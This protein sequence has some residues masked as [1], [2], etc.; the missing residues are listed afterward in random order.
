MRRVILYSGGLDSYLMYRYACFLGSSDTV[1]NVWYD[2]GQPYN[3]KERQAIQ[4]LGLPVD[5]KQVDWLSESNRASGKEGSASGDIYI[6]GRNLVLASLA[7]CQYTPD[8]VWLGALE[9]EIHDR[10]TDKNFQFRDKTS[11]LLS[12]VLS[13]FVP[14][15]RLSFPFAEQHW[16]KLDIV[17]LALSEWGVTKEELLVTSSCLSGEHGNCGSCVVCLRRWG[18]FTQLG[19]EELYNRDPLQT[20]EL[21]T[22]VTAM[23]QGQHY[24]DTR[25][26]EILGA[27]ETLSIDPEDFL[28]G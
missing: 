21:R 27:F 23:L 3:F 2:I 12:Y 11:E 26:Q 5:I 7:A 8:E 15:V 17:R 14:S 16:S 13:P 6:P 4:A 24:D 18:I 19:L 28:N 22:L 1:T 25:K 9:G 10:A 20:A